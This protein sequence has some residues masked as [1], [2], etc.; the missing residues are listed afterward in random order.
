MRS[1]WQGLRRR[2]P[3]AFVQGDS[4]WL[5]LGLLPSIDLRHLGGFFGVKPPVGCLEGA[6]PLRQVGT[7]ARLKWHC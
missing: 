5:A 4:L 1:K 2:D 6:S 7:F 3:A